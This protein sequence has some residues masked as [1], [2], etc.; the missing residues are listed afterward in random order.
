MG[1]QII[2]RDVAPHHV[3]GINIT[4]DLDSA[5]R[6]DG[7]DMTVI[8]FNVPGEDIREQAKEIGEML[9][10]IAGMLTDDEL[11]A[12]GEAETFDIPLPSTNARL[13]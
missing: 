9:K 7:P 10:L 1:I 8:A 4:M 13:N 12:S 3:A 5:E 11:L 6:V 2:T